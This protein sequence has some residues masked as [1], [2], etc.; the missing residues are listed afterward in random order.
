[1]KEDD[2]KAAMMALTDQAHLARQ[3][4]YQSHINQRN[5]A[6]LSA[7]KEMESQTDELLDANAIDVAQAR[8]RGL[9]DA[10]IDGIA[11]ATQ[12]DAI[13]RFYGKSGGI[14][15]HIGARFKN[16]TQYPKRRANPANI[17]SIWPCPSRQFN[18][19]RIIRHRFFLTDSL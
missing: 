2:A 4:M 8:T 13:C 18:T 5:A 10:Y 17:Q 19:N 15:R 3:Q 7:A 9:T 16:N 1:M 14:N 6:L 11:A 12:N